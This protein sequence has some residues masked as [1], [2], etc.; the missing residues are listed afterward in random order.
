MRLIQYDSDNRRNKALRGKKR[1][2]PK[3]FSFFFFA[4]AQ[5]IESFRPCGV[6][7]VKEGSF[8][9]HKIVTSRDNLGYSTRTDLDKMSHRRQVAKLKK[10]KFEKKR[11]KWRKKIGSRDSLGTFLQLLLDPNSDLIQSLAHSS[12]PQLGLSGLE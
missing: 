2:S 8:L 5:L 4:P 7:R 3:G 11:K 6:T 1:A 9:R 10:D 12:S